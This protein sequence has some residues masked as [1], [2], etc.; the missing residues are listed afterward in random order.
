MYHFNQQGVHFALQKAGAGKTSYPP[1]RLSLRSIS[2]Y[3]IK[4]VAVNHTPKS[5]SRLSVL[6]YAFSKHIKE[7]IDVVV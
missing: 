2:T 4:H 7:G 1:Q 3:V 5:E 6:E